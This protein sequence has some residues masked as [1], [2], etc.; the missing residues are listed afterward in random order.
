MEQSRVRTFGWW[1]W[2]FV[3]ASAFADPPEASAQQAAAIV[4]RIDHVMIVTA[5][6]NGLVA[7]FADTLQ[8]PVVWGRPGSDFTATT[9]IALGDVN[10]EFVP[11][12]GAAR[13]L[14]TRFAMQ[15]ADL[16]TACDELLRRGF[17]LIE[18]ASCTEDPGQRRWTAVTIRHPFRG[19][20]FFLIQYLNFDMDLRRTRFEQALEARQGG[21]LGLRRVLEFRITVSTEEMEAMT[22][23]WRRLLG[24][25]VSTQTRR[26]A[27]QAGPS[28]VLMTGG[29]PA[30][31]TL[32]V[33]VESLVRAEKT[34]RSLRLLHAVSTDSLVLDPARFGGLQLIL[35]PRWPR[36]GDAARS[37]L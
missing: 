25:P 13:A 17:D 21:P 6:R 12:T 29:P 27:P 33:E 8:L 28:V 16:P 35:V 18:P 19:A 10:L 32:V 3:L 24:T 14:V 4:T 20:G 26:F 1:S 30:P 2:L 11:R 31:S 15:P 9:G 36:A 37:Q 23:S 34:A 5:N 22:G 7:L